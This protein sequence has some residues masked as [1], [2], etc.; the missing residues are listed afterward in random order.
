MRVLLFVL[1]QGCKRPD[2]Q[3]EEQ[4]GE[5]RTPTSCLTYSDLHPYAYP[6]ACCSFTALLT[7]KQEQTLFKGPAA[8]F[9]KV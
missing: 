3:V 9:D 8:G 4:D 6:Y 1:V 5:I 2:R 7:P